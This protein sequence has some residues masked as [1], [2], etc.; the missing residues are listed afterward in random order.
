M[1]A[2]CPHT[3]ELTAPPQDAAPQPAPVAPQAALAPVAAATSS[4]AIRQL[5]ALARVAV[6]SA[7]IIPRQRD[8]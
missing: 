1:R 5:E 4:E 2:L 3:A 7:W 8:R 6:V